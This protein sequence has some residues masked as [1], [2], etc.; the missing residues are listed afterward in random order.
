MAQA[1]A[2]TDPRMIPRPGPGGAMPNPAPPGG[3]SFPG[4]RPQGIVN[5]VQTR[6]PQFEDVFAVL[7]ALPDSAP[8]K[9]KKARKILVYARARGYA[10]SSVPIT[11]FAIDELGKKT[12]AWSA[13]ISY[14][15][16][17][18]TAANLANYDVLVLVSTTGAFLDDPNDAVGTAARKAALLDYVRSGHGLVLTHAVGD[19]Y[20]A[21]SPTGP[22]G[23]WPEWNKTVGGIFK[24]HWV[25]PQ[26]VTVKID[27]PRNPINAGFGRQPFII[28]DEI[29]TF[30]QDSFSRKNARVLTSVDYAKMSDAD[31]A[32]EP[33]AT[34]RTDGDYPL[35]W[36]RREC[37]GRVFYEV[38]GHSEHVLAMPAILQQ[39]TAGIQYAA[40]DLTVDDSPSQK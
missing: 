14:D 1:P 28:H 31:K 26:Q 16:D 23:T 12:G 34:R 40:G 38:L 3:G 24:Y 35:S 30:A 21:N 37:K 22:V 20:R 19:S 27:D 17:D 5:G 9:P 33:A 2:V 36:I 29:Y 18:F 39:I 10:H 11:A 25:Y 15:Q 4:Y 6:L 32:Q 7:D 8:A 13:T